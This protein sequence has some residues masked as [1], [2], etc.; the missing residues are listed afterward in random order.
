MDSI[1]YYILTFAQSIFHIEII[2]L[3]GKNNNVFGSFNKQQRAKSKKKEWEKSRTQ[4]K[5][6]KFCSSVETIDNDDDKHR[7]NN[8]NCFW[9]CVNVKVAY[10]RSFVF[11]KENVKQWVQTR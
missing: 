2:K 8:E 10:F 6:K 1:L 9:H 11:K 7:G 5:V 3:F 4:I